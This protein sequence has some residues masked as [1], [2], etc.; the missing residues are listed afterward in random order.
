LNN[1]KTYGPPAGKI[2]MGFEPGNQFGGGVWEGIDI[3]TEVGKFIR[4]Q[5]F[6]GAMIWPINPDPA[7]EPESAQW[8]PVLAQ[9]LNKII[10]PQWPFGKTPTY[11]KCNPSTGW[12]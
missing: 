2:N 6:G 11:S 5:D 4:N 1:F 7:V 10:A 12:L 8:C 3:D 9:A